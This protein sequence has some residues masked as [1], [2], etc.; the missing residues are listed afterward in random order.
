VKT[1]QTFCDR[2]SAVIIDGGSIISPKAG[3]LSRW[4]SESLDLCSACGLAF[5]A[6]MQPERSPVANGA[7]LARPG[8]P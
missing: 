5:R 3:E 7:G 2:C 4:Y 6:W 8:R 1:S